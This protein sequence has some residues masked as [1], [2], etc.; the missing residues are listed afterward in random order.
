MNKKTNLIICAFVLILSAG[1]S[2]KIY[3]SYDYDKDV[4]FSKY[5]S[6]NFTAEANESSLDQLTKKR[7]FV[8]V[9]EALNKKNFSWSEKPDV[10]VH[11]HVNLIK[12][13]KQSK[14]TTTPM[15]KSESYKIG[16]EYIGSYIDAGEYA[17][18]TLFIDIVDA[19]TMR[20]IWKSVGKVE[21]DTE[22]KNPDKSLR[23]LVKKMFRS[24]PPK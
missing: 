19:K 18:G 14:E 17:R 9:S 23:K 24:F 13:K 4:N 20:L 5:S 15:A 22:N 10:Y 21:I 7:I 16:D 12:D 3:V 8:S 1:C 2:K 6:Y 11:F